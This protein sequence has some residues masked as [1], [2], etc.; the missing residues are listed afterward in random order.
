MRCHDLVRV[1]SFETQKGFTL[2]ELMVVVVIMAVVVSVGVVSLGS[3]N[4][5]LT[6]T[7]QAKLQ[8]YLKQ[9][10]DEAAFKQRLYLLVPDESGLSLYAKIN[11]QWQAEQSI[12]KFAWHE[13]FEASWQLD[14]TMVRQQQLPQAGWLFWPSGEVTPGLIKLDMADQNENQTLSVEWDQWLDFKRADDE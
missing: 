11:F 1:E 14:E 10:S 7:E 13:G 5:N 12:E 9:V 2:I 4:Q 3:F 8:S 6:A